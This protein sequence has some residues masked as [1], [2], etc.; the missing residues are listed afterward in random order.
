MKLSCEY[1]GEQHDVD[2]SVGF[3][4]IIFVKLGLAIECPTHHAKT[5]LTPRP[6]VEMN[7]GS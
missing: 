5:V 7:T 4:Q 2:L 6:P 1:P 3:L